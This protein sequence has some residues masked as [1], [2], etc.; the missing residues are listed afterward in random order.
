M[1]WGNIGFFK[2]ASE[3]YNINGMDFL[4]DNSG[5][6]AVVS[7]AIGD[8][9]MR[10]QTPKLKIYEL[11]EELTTIFQSIKQNISLSEDKTTT[12]VATTVDSK[13]KKNQPKART[14]SKLKFSFSS[15]LPMENWLGVFNKFPSLEI[16]SL[17]YD[18]YSNIWTYEGQIYEPIF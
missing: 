14:Y 13:K 18:P 16:L 4:I 3:E 15:E 11:R 6:S 5:N 10:S 12:Q 17:K 8:L 7:L 2:R 1:E 9:P